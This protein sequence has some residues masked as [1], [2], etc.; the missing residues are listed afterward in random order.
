MTEKEIRFAEIYD[1]YAKVL[2][3]FMYYKTGDI[4]M[5]NDYAQES[6]TRY[7]Q[8]FEKVQHSKAK[9]Y[10]FTVAN[11]RHLGQVG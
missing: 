1:Q 10:P 6:F 2:R 7:W 11:N 3:N 8:N 5:A 9:S 4:D